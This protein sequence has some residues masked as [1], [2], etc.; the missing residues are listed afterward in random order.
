MCWIREWQEELWRQRSLNSKDM[1]TLIIPDIHNK[2]IDAEVMIAHEKPDNII[3]LGDYFDGFNDS[4]EIAY[5]VASWLK[6]SLTKT[7]RIHLIGNH[8]IS[9]MTNGKHGCAGWDGAKQ[10]FINKVKINWKLLEHY[11]WVGDWLCTHAGLSN[12]FYKAY[13][14]KEE[15]TNDFLHRYSTDLE[16]KSRLYDVSP[17]RGGIDAFGGILWCDYDEFVDI[18]NLKQIFGHTHGELRQTEK[19]ICL[20]TFLEY[21]A[22]YNGEMKVKKI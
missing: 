7:N 20:D 9:Y 4:P 14:D 22:I 12:E 5:Q 3:F 18:P 13:K 17:F 1:R 15:S 8:D 21:Y 2:F 19:H 16:L 6:D 11:C 10:M